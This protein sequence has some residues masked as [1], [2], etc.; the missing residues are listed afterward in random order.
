M[1]SRMLHTKGSEVAGSKSE[2]NNII[3]GIPQGFIIGPL[4]LQ[5][6][7]NDLANVANVLFTALFPADSNRFITGD[8]RNDLVNTM[9]NEIIKVID[10]LRTNTLT[11]NTDKTY[12]VLFRR[13][14]QLAN[15][16]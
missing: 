8:D 3:C 14:R 10:W 12:P 2:L 16:T 5:W 11:L 7:I 1:A 15:L 9:N 6:Y 13:Q 4:L